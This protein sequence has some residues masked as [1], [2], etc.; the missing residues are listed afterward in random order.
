M[1]RWDKIV[2]LGAS[3]TVA[4]Q[5]RN[6]FDQPEAYP[7]DWLILPLQTLEAALCAD[8]RGF[9]APGGITLVDGLPRNRRFP[10]VMPHDFDPAATGHEKEIPQVQRKYDAL[11]D[12]WR[13]L[14][15]SRQ[16]VLFVRYQGEFDLSD[17]TVIQRVPVARANALVATIAARAPNLSFSVMFVTA[18]DNDDRSELDPRAIHAEVSRPTEDDWPPDLLWRGNTREWRD[19]FTQVAGKPK[20]ADR[21]APN[22]AIMPRS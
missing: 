22:L 14:L 6:H 15:R 10:A 16:R 9:V 18:I 3:C 11:G 1:S 12:R 8:V 21:S 13:D 20:A 7:F 19:L 5:I 2:S 4:W 17:D